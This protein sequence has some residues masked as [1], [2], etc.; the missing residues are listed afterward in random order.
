MKKIFI[1][2]GFLFLNSAFIYSL[3]PKGIIENIGRST[4]IS[5]R[6][7]K[8]TIMNVVYFKEIKPV[9]IIEKKQKNE[10]KISPKSIIDNIS[11]SENVNIQ[12][13]NTSFEK[14]SCSPPL[15]KNGRCMIS[16]DE[17]FLNYFNIQIVKEFQNMKQSL[18]VIK[19]TPEGKITLKFTEGEKKAEVNG[20]TFLL[21]VAPYICNNNLMI[22]LRFLCE[23]LGYKIAY[24]SHNVI[25]ET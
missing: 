13:N 3:E 14:N 20:K 4:E 9:V 16:L 17:V 19:E 24:I 8:P 7:I 12:I 22:P 11:V 6:E 21:D 25:I 10:Y 5:L 18:Y 23:A 2:I 15:I 1:I